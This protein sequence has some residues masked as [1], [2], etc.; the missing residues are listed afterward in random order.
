M[1]N[2]T[3]M[4]GAAGIRRAMIAA[5]KQAAAAD[6]LP[7][8]TLKLA[9]RRRPTP[10]TQARFRPDRTLDQQFELETPEQIWVADVT[11]V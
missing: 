1:A 8:P 3:V 9:R 11:S 4:I 5:E 2:W 6:Q 10:H 7:P